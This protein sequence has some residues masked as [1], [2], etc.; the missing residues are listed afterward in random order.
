LYYDK[1]YGT[2]QI[3]LL[4][5]DVIFSDEISIGNYLELNS[6][7]LYIYLIKNDLQCITDEN[8]DPAYDYTYLF[9]II[10]RRFEKSQV[11]F[12]KKQLNLDNVLNNESINEYS[13]GHY[14][15]YHFRMKKENDDEKK[16]FITPRI[17]CFGVIYNKLL[18][19]NT[20]N[21]DIEE[22]SKYDYLLYESV[23]ALYGAIRFAMTDLEDGKEFL[24]YIY[25]EYDEKLISNE[26]D[27][28]KADLVKSISLNLIPLDIRFGLNKIMLAYID[29]NIV[30]KETLIIT[31]IINLITTVYPVDADEELVPNNIEELKHKIGILSIEQRNH[32]N[33]TFRNLIKFISENTQLEDLT[34]FMLWFYDELELNNN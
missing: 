29:E 2:A 11:N 20:S 31:T 16:I 12:E 15:E 1:G 19:I 33:S 9:D 25:P 21:F 26:I 10:Y 3:S 7:E 13:F 14:Q 34:K 18:S 22:N 28:K 32:L 27:T 30:E 5:R 23:S 8:D 4:E 6:L 24:K 17:I